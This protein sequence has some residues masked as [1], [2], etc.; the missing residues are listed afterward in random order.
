M[1]LEI[2]FTLLEKDDA[3]REIVMVREKRET[4][5]RGDEW[6]AD[7]TAWRVMRRQK[8]DELRA[9]L[10]QKQVEWLRFLSKVIFFCFCFLVDVQIYTCKTCKSCN[11][12]I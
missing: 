2:C 10:C 8:Y 11:I 5:H 1:T 9:Q 7:K 3:W 12:Q 4:K 6:R